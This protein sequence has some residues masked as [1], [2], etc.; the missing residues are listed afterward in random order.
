MG[1][2][3]DGRSCKR[4][5]TSEQ[6]ILRKRP[7]TATAAHG[8]GPA[9]GHVT[10][11]D[12]A[13]EKVPHL[14]D[15]VRYGLDVTDVRIAI[16]TFGR[17]DTLC[18]ATLPLLRR[19]GFPME[20]VHI[21]ISPRQAAD[22][23][24]PEWFRYLTA[25]RREGYD[26]VHLEVGR[27]GLENQMHSIFTW[28]GSGYLIVMTDDV[29]DVL[30][31]KVPPGAD[32]RLEP[33]PLGMLR[34]LFLHGRDLLVAT[35]CFAWSLSASRNLR[36]MDESKIP[37]RFGLLEGNLTGFRLE[38]N[39]ESW[40]VEANMGVI[41]DVA[42][43]CKLWSTGRR[44]LRYRSMCLD[45]RYRAEG[46]YRSTMDLNARRLQ[47]DEAIKKLEGRHGDLVRFQARP[48]S[49]A[50]RMNFQM[51]SQGPGPLVLKAPAP[52]TAGRR[53][54]GFA[55]RPMSASERQRRHRHG[56]RAFD[57]P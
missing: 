12:V 23:Q 45:H 53:Y 6:P 56:K 47:E 42:L 21:F 4:P 25:L 20:Q 8:D 44:F 18:N 37:R 9:L 32:A 10:F 43:S 2:K 1:P 19:H 49:G 54:E 22:S 27:D 51:L 31:R 38:G 5:R 14:Y 26:T 35:D 28:A 39:P 11:A 57:A 50:G 36:S 29:R 30:V 7:A 34:A 48:E 15:V 17:P 41:Y 52:I 16:P 40:R 55:H 46:G 3:R 24:D 33:L 13:R